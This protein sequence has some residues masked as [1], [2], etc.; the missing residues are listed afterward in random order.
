[1]SQRH[2]P[3]AHVYELQH[4]HSKIWRDFENGVYSQGQPFFKANNKFYCA[5]VLVNAI[6]YDNA[7][8]FN[9]QNYL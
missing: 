1:M 4:T 2:L 9:I 3:L 8:L 7:Y 6:F 5:L